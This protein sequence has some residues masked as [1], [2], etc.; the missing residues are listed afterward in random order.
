MLAASSMSNNEDGSQNKQPPDEGEL[1]FSNPGLLEH[2]QTL[3]VNL[4]LRTAILFCHHPAS[5]IRLVKQQKLTPHGIR[6]LVPLLR[7]YPHYCPYEVLLASLFPLSLEEGHK[8]RDDAWEKKIRALRR[9]IGSLQ[10]GLRPFGLKVSS[11]LGSGYVLSRSN[12][13]GITK[14]ND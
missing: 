12:P 1:H 9:A 4:A 14:K 7:A 10:E 11:V 8:P 3:V 5:A 13:V 6:A 2:N